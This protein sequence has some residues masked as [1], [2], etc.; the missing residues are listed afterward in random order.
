[1]QSDDRLRNELARAE[2]ECNRLR[3]ENA[4]LKARLGENNA[5]P[6][7]KPAPI[8]RPIAND[9][10]RTEASESITNSSHADLKVSLFRN[11]FRGRG[12]VY[13]IRWEGKGGKT[14][15]S[16]AGIRD[17]EHPSFTKTGKKKPFRVSRPFPLSDDVVRDHLLGKQTIGVYPLLQDDTCWF[18]AV[19]F[20]K[21]SWEA[22]ACAFLKTCRETGV[23]A[24]FERS[25]S[26]N[27]G[28]VWIF[29]AEPV[30]AALARK[31]ASAIL[32]R[33]ME[34]HYALGLDSYDRLFPSQDT[35]PKGGFGNLIALPLQHEP[36]EK[37]N[38]VFVDD[39]LRPYDDQWAYVSSIERLTLDETQSV[40]RRIY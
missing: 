35:M 21:R 24:S 31:L 34:Q 3:E 27:G 22:D 7:I 19:D 13:A 20:D 33:T 16:P 25:R 8:H 38:S 9:N 2:A 11:L 36:R 18:V 28:H 4:R 39:R 40:L 23:P 12:D 10:H 15:Y 37:G 30:Q 6:S 32:S 17:W 1:M 14:G 29:F 26:G 5:S